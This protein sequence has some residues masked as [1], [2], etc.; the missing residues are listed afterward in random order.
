MSPVQTVSTH[1]TGTTALQVNHT[2]LFPSVTVSF[3]LAPGMSLS[4]ASQEVQQMEERLGMPSTVRG[5]F[6]G[7]LQAYQQS[8]S[9]RA[10]SRPDGIAGGLHRSGHSL[11]E[12]GSSADDHFHSAFRE[13]GRDAGAD[14]LPHGS[15]C[16]FDHWHRAAD[17][18]CE[19]ERHHD[20]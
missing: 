7:T 15:E 4:E 19:E 3:N 9:T 5:F 6:S 8:L 11:R 13:C 17:R 10:N 2:G 12:P 18:D 16:D 20:D 1:Q 14:A